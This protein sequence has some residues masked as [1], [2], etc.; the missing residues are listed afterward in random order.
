MASD[1]RGALIDPVFGPCWRS[2]AATLTS[3]WAGS[4]RMMPLPCCAISS[5]EVVG[6]ILLRLEVM[7]QIYRPGWAGYAVKCLPK[8]TENLIFSDDFLRAK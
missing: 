2:E 5:M 6:R 1:I 4:Y 8:S 3:I 7:T